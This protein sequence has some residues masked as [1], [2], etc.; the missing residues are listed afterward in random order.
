MVLLELVL[1]QLHTIKLRS[2]TS[3]LVQLRKRLDSS[4][5]WLQYTA[6]DTALRYLSPAA[7]P[8]GCPSGVVPC[9]LLSPWLTATIP[10]SWKVSL[11]QHAAQDPA[12]LSFFDQLDAAS[13]QQQQQRWIAEGGA[14]GEGKP[15]QPQQQQETGGS[16][17]GGGPYGCRLPKAELDVIKGELETA[18]VRVK[19]EAMSGNPEAWPP[20]CV[21]V[22]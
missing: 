10:S 5:H 9:A 2:I 22:L 15:Q 3:C 17:G 11:A 19:E 21:F 20:R 16:S 6:I 7:L 14:V 1:P 8:F 4:Q 13:T 18:L 12:S